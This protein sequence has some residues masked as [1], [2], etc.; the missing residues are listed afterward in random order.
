MIPFRSTAFIATAAV[1]AATPAMAA[2]ST[3]SVQ[4]SAEAVATPVQVKASGMLYSS[5]GRRIG[6]IYRLDATGSPQIILNG[7][8]ITI[9]VETLSDAGGKL[10]T[11]LTHKEASNLN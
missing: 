7:R 9:S 1:F 6:R 3:R 2:E 5:D 11:S 8:L 10:T 4:A